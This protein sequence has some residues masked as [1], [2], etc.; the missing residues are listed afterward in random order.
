[1]QPG[2]VAQH[3]ALSGRP[4]PGRMWN[5]MR[6]IV[7]FGTI[8]FFGHPKTFS[9]KHSEYV[10]GNVSYIANK[11]FLWTKNRGTKTVTEQVNIQSVNSFVVSAPV[12]PR[13]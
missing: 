2:P 1:M 7:E 6:G 4:N 12:K 13:S 10:H 9:Y 5:S 11:V 8:G 3:Q